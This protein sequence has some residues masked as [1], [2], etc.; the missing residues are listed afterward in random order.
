MAVSRLRTA[1]S[2]SCILECGGGVRAI[3]PAPSV[4]EGRPVRK[5]TPL[6]LA[7]YTVDPARPSPVAS[8]IF[9]TF[10]KLQQSG[11]FF[12]KPFRIRSYKNTGLK[13][14]CFHTLTKNIGG[15]GSVLGLRAIDARHKT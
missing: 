2:H 1:R 7:Q 13:M 3:E 14:S 8:A 11:I 9:Y 12:R 6:C 10:S 4:V 15:R 5:L